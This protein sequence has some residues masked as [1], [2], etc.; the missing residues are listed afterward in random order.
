MEFENPSL[1]ADSLATAADKLTDPLAGK[2]AISIPRADPRAEK[3]VISSVAQLSLDDA[4]PHTSSLPL[5]ADFFASIIVDDNIVP[6]PIIVPNNQVPP[7][8][9]PVE[10]YEDL[11]IDPNISILLMLTM[12]V[13]AENSD[14]L[15][16]SKDLNPELQKR[17]GN[18]KSLR[19]NPSGA[20]SKH[21]T[22]SKTS[23]LDKME[24]FVEQTGIKLRPIL[25]RSWE[26]KRLRWTT[27]VPANFVPRIFS[28]AKTYSSLAEIALF[29]S[30]PEWKQAR[31]YS[32]NDYAEFLYD[33]VQQFSVPNTETG[34]MHHIVFNSNLINSVIT[35]LREN[36]AILVATGSQR[37]VF[38]DTADLMRGA[39]HQLDNG[40][41]VPLFEER[42]C[43][44]EIWW[45][46]NKAIVPYECQLFTRYPSTQW[47]LLFKNSL[48][49]AM[50]QMLLQPV[51]DV[52]VIPFRAPEA[53]A[54][55][56]EA[57][58]DAVEV[59]DAPQPEAQQDAVEVIDSLPFDFNFDNIDAMNFENFTF[60]EAEL[61]FLFPDTNQPAAIPT[62][63]PIDP[64]NK[65]PLPT[66]VQ[67]NVAPET[68]TPVQSILDSI[69]APQPE[70]C[71]PEMRP[72]GAR[73]MHTSTE[74]PTDHEV[75]LYKSAVTY[76]KLSPYERMRALARDAATAR[77]IEVEAD[78]DA[79]TD[80]N[81]RKR[82]S[83]EGK[84]S[85]SKRNKSSSESDSE[86]HT[87][88]PI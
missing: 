87:P 14:K 11:Y 64:V 47:R 80:N 60:N 71:M 84:A 39:K 21:M 49:A 67:P 9:T 59:N 35:Y 1:L 19:K 51:E 41:L 57:P 66:S 52:F 15:L 24:A 10:S 58:Q 75:A 74:E 44:G 81:S 22:G 5:H 30:V 43:N 53:L 13:C 83:F 50:F 73:Q 26:G 46:I 6:P 88:F 16:S 61:N 62:P 17:A 3:S 28:S 72:D 56:P 76:E 86:D 77:R 68:T 65:Q 42:K 23:Y 70:L 25:D 34:A 31:T 33:L 54:P 48:P 85:P 29:S 55:Q 20:L 4:V 18:Y 78:E 12:V 38:R 8:I 45:L 40:S 63:V 36:T 2:S 7:A 82:T 32:C 79:T 69:P 37:F 27:V